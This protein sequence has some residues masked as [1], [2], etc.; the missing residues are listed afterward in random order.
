MKTLLSDNSSNN[1]SD[2]HI[3]F[4]QNFIIENLKKEDH[5]LIGIVTKFGG[6]CELICNFLLKNNILTDINEN[7]D[8]FDCIT[9]KA[10]NMTEIKTS[11]LLLVYSLFHKIIAFLFKVYPD[12]IFS[13][14]DQW[15][16]VKKANNTISV[17]EKLFQK[18]LKEIKINE[19]LKF[20][21]FS[22]TLTGLEGHSMLI[23][24]TGE[25][26]YIF[27]D[28]NEGADLNLNLN[29]LTEKVNSALNEYRGTDLFFTKGSDF[30]KRLPK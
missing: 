27:F 13:C 20:E 26:T 4:D 9:L 11:H 1:H 15:K 3:P 22:K 25:E 5:E 18:K 30:L 14:F 12:N 6:L 24:K 2:N 7:H 23:K 21:V 28:P 16:L 19:T 8:P 10:I 29:D 17:N